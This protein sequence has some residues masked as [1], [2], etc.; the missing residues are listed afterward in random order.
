LHGCSLK[1]FRPNHRHKQI[2]EEQQRDD[3]DDDGFHGI[4]LQL[5]AEADIKS[6]HDKK[7]NDD[8]SE[9]EVVHRFPF[10]CSQKRE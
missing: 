6:A 10:G 2:N 1:F 8:A 7:Q 4:L 3:T 5:L 9:N